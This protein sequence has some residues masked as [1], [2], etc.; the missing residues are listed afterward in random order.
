MANTESYLNLSL[1]R[2]D[3]LAVD[4]DPR[5]S[6][7]SPEEGYRLMRHFANIRQPALREA[8][9]DLVTRLAVGAEVRRENL[10]VTYRYKL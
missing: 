8:V 4:Q 5:P 10:S 7:P 3:A 2:P 9:I 6:R 1:V